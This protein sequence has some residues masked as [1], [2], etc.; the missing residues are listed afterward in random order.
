MAGCPTISFFH[1]ES[2]RNLPPPHGA[3]RH[4]YKSKRTIKHEEFF[5]VDTPVGYSGPINLKS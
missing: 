2:D 5:R 4:L 1:P 3:D